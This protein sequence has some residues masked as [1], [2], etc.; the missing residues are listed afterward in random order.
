[1][2]DI[3]QC[4]RHLATLRT[5]STPVAVSAHPARHRRPTQHRRHSAT[6]CT[7]STHVAPSAHC[8]A[9]TL[10]TTSTH[11][12]PQKA[13]FVA[14]IWRKRGMRFVRETHP[15]FPPNPRHEC[16]LNTGLRFAHE[17]HPSFPPNPRNGCRFQ[18]LHHSLGLGGNEGCVSR[19]KRIPRFR[20]IQAM[21]DVQGC[22][23]PVKRNPDIWP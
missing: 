8:I 13:S 11:T 2:V 10:C 1:M 3:A 21:K 18:N 22:V 7:A 16:F 19:T 23:S 5:A 15:S 4:R 20:Q 17:T 12:F 6:R 14:W 9:S